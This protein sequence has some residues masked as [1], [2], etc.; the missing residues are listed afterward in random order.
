MNRIKKLFRLVHIVLWI[1]FGLLAALQ[2]SQD[3]P[4][5]W[6]TLTVGLLL[7]VLYVFY[8]HFI[9]LTRF[10]RKRK[11]GAYFLRLAGIML[12]GPFPYLFFQP[13]IMFRHRIPMWLRAK[14]CS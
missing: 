4:Q 1:L 8:S 5:Y 13:S 7:S 12:T 6:P 9:L 11:K 2:L 14:P 10:S 3:T